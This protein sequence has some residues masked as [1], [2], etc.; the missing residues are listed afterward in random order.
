MGKNGLGKSGQI[1][2]GLSVL[3]GGKNTFGFTDEGTKQPEWEFEVVDEES[4]GIVKQPKM[5]IA[6]KNLGPQ[7]IK[8]VALGEPIVLRGNIRD[9]GEDKPL[10]ITVEG[11][12]IK[13]SGEIKEGDSTKREFE[14]RV[15]RYQEV[16]DYNETIIYNRHPYKFILGG[17]DK[18]PNFNK[19][20]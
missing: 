3:F 6:V 20:I 8:H 16:V 9:D 14:I 17:V 10:S 7:Y 19:N 2:T 11:P 5:T 1:L 12:L 4:T 18:A 15:D 13:M